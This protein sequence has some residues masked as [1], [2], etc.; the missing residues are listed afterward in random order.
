M[1]HS[2]SPKYNDKPDTDKWVYNTR[3]FLQTQNALLVSLLQGVSFIKHL[4]RLLLLS[5]VNIDQCVP[6]V[7]NN[8][9]Y[10]NLSH[11]KTLQNLCIVLTLKYVSTLSKTYWIADGLLEHEAGAT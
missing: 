10:Y 3:E 9:L 4:Q 8:Q 11:C 7:N 6:P 2:Y 1:L 5:L